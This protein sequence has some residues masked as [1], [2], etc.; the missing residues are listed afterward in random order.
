MFHYKK[1]AMKCPQYNAARSNNMEKDP[2]AEAKVHHL[3][4]SPV[5]EL[6][7]IKPQCPP[8][9]T[10]VLFPL[11]TADP[12]GAVHGKENS[13]D[14]EHERTLEESVEDSGYLSLHN[15]HN[16]VYHVD[17]EDDHIQPRCKESLPSFSAST[18][19]GKSISPKQSPTKCKGRRESSQ[20]VSLAS[21]TPVNCQK[22]RSLTYS[23]SSTPAHHADRNLPLLNFERAVCEKLAKNFRKNK[24]YY[25]NI[26]IT[27]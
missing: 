9:V 1:V 25:I 23:L 22:R 26:C 3:K 19:Q 13:T 12:T 20:P 6:V 2:A 27:L 15:S 10:T 18:H 24:R 7:F 16:E 5:K 14:K 17:E 4:A 11:N 8:S 21:S